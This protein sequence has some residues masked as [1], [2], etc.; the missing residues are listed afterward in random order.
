MAEESVSLAFN[1]KAETVFGQCV[2]VVGSTPELGMWDVTKAPALQTDPSEYPRWFGNVTCAGVDTEYKFVKFDPCKPTVWEEGMNRFFTVNDDGDVLTRDGQ[3]GEPN[4]PTFSVADRYA[5]RLASGRSRKTSISDEVDQYAVPVPVTPKAKVPTSLVD[6]NDELHFTVVCQYTGMGDGVS[7]VGSCPE[8]GNWD[9]RKGVGLCTSPEL[10]PTWSGVIHLKSCAFRELEFKVVICHMSSEDWESN[11]NR[12][13]SLPDD[14]EEGPWEAFV[15]FNVNGCDVKKFRTTPIHKTSNGHGKEDPVFVKKALQDNVNKMSPV[16]GARFSATAGCNEPRRSTSL[17]LLVERAPLV[18]EQ[19]G[20]CRDISPS[21][22]KEHCLILKLK[23]ISQCDAKK[24]FVEVVFEARSQKPTLSLDLTSWEAEELQAA[25]S[26]AITAA[27]LPLGINFFH[28]RVNGVFALSG[29]HIRIGRWNALHHSD[30]IRRYLLAR[31]SHGQLLEEGLMIEKTR[32]KRIGDMA[33][34]TVVGDASSADPTG[35]QDQESAGPIARPYSVCGHLALAES[36]EEHDVQD[37]ANSFAPFQ[38]EVYEGLFD[39]ELMLRLDGVVLPEVPQPPLSWQ[40]ED[41]GPALRL[42]AG[43]HLLKKAHGACEDAYFVD[44]HG[45]G[46][47]D[48]VGCMVQFASYGINAAQYAA[49]LMEF[50]SAALKPDGIASEKKIPNDVA[51]RA[52]TAMLHGE[53]HAAAYGAS[54]VAVL[55]QQGSFLGVANLGD[56]GFMVLRKGPLGMSVVIKSEEQQHSWNCPYQLTRLPK[57]LLTRFPKLQLDKASDCERYTV[58]IKEGDLVIMFS[59]G[60]RDNLHDREVVSLVNRSLPP[61]CADLVGLL[62]RCTPPETIAKTLALAAQERS[63]DPSAKVPFVE[64]S[65]RH[66]FECI[67]GKQD[68]ITV[69]CAWVVADESTP[70]PDAL[71]LDEIVE[72][73][74][75]EEEAEEERK[76]VEEEERQRVE[77][78]ERQRV[79]EVVEVSIDGEKSPATSN[80]SYEYSFAAEGDVNEE[81]DGEGKSNGSG[82]RRRSRGDKGEMAKGGS[83]RIHAVKK[84]SS[85][86]ERKTGDAS[87][88]ELRSGTRTQFRPMSSSKAA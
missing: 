61:M 22:I 21:P 37:G 64:Y 38:K 58:P 2:R 59:D 35:L 54:T 73:M 1:V 83:G 43:A 25:W 14:D 7:V 36:D 49:E 77:E 34:D 56:S 86:F 10:F 53:S 29:E 69:V 46:V 82:R 12:R 6:F 79:E 57:T 51:S 24:M 85:S 30:P 47:A 88:K 84:S 50:S 3:P 72:D 67:G 78:E 68:D 66:G 41:T 74:L 62:D 15:K 75:L 16:N 48:G 71:D 33:F 5:P 81:E 76:R 8:L 45:M 32:S 40:G 26:L 20:R 80:V 52:A 60:L 31:D 19:W 13:L 44:P 17:S 63:M 42:W 27:E 23:G 39:R 11:Q 70:D 65:K 28:F 9:A 4:T 87:K 55:C 18:A